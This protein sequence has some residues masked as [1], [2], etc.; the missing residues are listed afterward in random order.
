M[1][2]HG[3]AGSGKTSLVADW[4]ATVD[5]SG[6]VVHARRARPRGL[7][8]LDESRRRDRP[9]ATGQSRRRSPRCCATTFAPDLLADE[10]IVAL[11][12]RDRRSGGA[13]ARRLPRDR[14]SARADRRVPSPRPAS[15]ARACNSSSISRSLPALSLD[16]ARLDGRLATVDF[17]D[18]RFD[19]AE[20]AELLG[21]LAPDADEAWVE[22]DDRPRRRVGGGAP[23]VRAGRPASTDARCRSR[24]RLPARRSIP[25]RAGRTRRVA[26]RD[27]R[28]RSGE[29]PD[30]P[31]A[32]ADETM[33]TCS[34]AGRSS[35]ICSCRDAAGTG[36]NCT[37][38]F[39]RC[40][41]A[42]LGEDPERAREL[43]ARAAADSE[44]D[45]EFADALE[46]WALAGRHR[47][48]LRLLS[49]GTPRAL[50]RRAATTSFAARSKPCRSTRTRPTSR[51]PWSSPGVRCSSTAVGSSM[52]SLGFPGGRSGRRSS[53]VLA[54]RL[55]LLQSVAATV[56][57]DWVE[58]GR[59]ARQSMAEL[60]PEWILDSYR[61]IRL[62][63]GGP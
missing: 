17:D 61:A 16:R 31:G 14:R 7:G 40:S 57:G 26:P 11:D 2:V 6:L 50:R 21:R 59:L 55:T 25:R 44:A 8:V 46:H 22:R 10:L 45:R 9:V 34:C 35:A 58:G 28:R 39:A 18:L 15:A 20:A 12:R 13:R 62:Q 29:R 54:A 38:S 60:G 47:E 49:D 23:A 42:Q 51:R 32:S 37:R 48:A 36:T 63:H 52:V 3:P 19:P 56:R 1:V 5:R 24:R 43:H 41:V 33:P 27:R 4:V 30:S 53:G